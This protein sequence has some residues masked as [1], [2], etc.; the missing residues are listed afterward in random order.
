MVGQKRPVL[1]LSRCRAV[2]CGERLDFRYQ[3]CFFDIGQRDLYELFCHGFPGLALLFDSR[4]VDRQYTVCEPGEAALPLAVFV[5]RR[6]CLELDEAS[7]EAG[8][9]LW[10]EELALE[11]RG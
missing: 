7:L 5:D 2:F 9:V 1:L 6:E 4:K 11:A 8:E 10:F 3:I